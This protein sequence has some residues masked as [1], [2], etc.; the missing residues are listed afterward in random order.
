MLC[1][2]KPAGQRGK[3]LSCKTVAYQ[4]L[5]PSCNQC[6][7]KHIIW[8]IHIVS[9]CKAASQHGPGKANA[10]ICTYEIIANPQKPNTQTQIKAQDSR[11]QPS[12]NHRLLNMI[13]CI[14]HILQPYMLGNDARKYAMMTLPTPLRKTA[15]GGL[16]AG[17]N[18]HGRP[19]TTTVLFPW[20]WSE[21]SW[22][23]ERPQ[24]LAGVN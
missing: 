1:C 21:M 17:P 6:M 19:C 7:V 2:R 9:Y 14:L 11:C 12:E 13:F 3:I 5:H 15:H 24:H 10:Y 4:N 18:Q 8:L 23:T 16:G 22:R 20:A